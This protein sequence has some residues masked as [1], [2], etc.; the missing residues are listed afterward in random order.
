MLEGLYKQNEYQRG[1]STWRE[2]GPR[3]RQWAL[4]FDPNGRHQGGSLPG[5]KRAAIHPSL[6]TSRAPPGQWI[7]QG[8]VQLPKTFTSCRSIRFEGFGFPGVLAVGASLHVRCSDLSSR[9]VQTPC[10]MAGSPLYIPARKLDRTSSPQDGHSSCC[11][12][13]VP[14]GSQLRCP[15]GLSQR[16]CHR[17]CQDPR[18]L[19]TMN[20]EE[21]LI[22]LTAVEAAFQSGD[23]TDC[24]ASETSF[25]VLL[26]FFFTYFSHA[27]LYCVIITWLLIKYSCMSV[28]NCI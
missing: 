2:R 23:N 1:I 14:R 15:G 18:G 25:S 20:S 19:E 6:L 7:S 22:K 9:H 8:M 24:F 17:H 13:S 16:I 3:V 11:P 4:L 12:A 28:R 26:T 27:E 21:V 10:L 5:W